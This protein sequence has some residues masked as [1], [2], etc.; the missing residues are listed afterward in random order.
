MQVGKTKEALVDY[1]QVIKLTPN[2]PGA[3]MLRAVAFK[4]LKKYDEAIADLSKVLELRNDDDDAYMERSECYRAMHRY[5]DA[6]A[7]LD[8]AATL[9][10]ASKTYVREARTKV[11]AE[12]NLAAAATRDQKPSSPQLQLSS[13]APD[14]SSGTTESPSS[15]TTQNQLSATTKS[16]SSSRTQTQ[17]SSDNKPLFLI[18]I[19]GATLFLLGLIAANKKNKS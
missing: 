7:D 19:I 4:S 18:M 15:T 14:H 12:M 16:Q 2:E 8:K 11:V 13:A 9:A 17:S 6:L 3:Y 1:S 10:H 5:Q